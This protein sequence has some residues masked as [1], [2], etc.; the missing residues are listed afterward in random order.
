MGIESAL[1]PVEKNERQ[2][3]R[4]TILVVR[5][6]RLLRILRR[7]A[8]HKVLVC[9]AMA[10]VPMAIRLAALRAIPIPQAWVHDEF[11]YILA[12]ETF[13]SGRLTNPTH[14]MWQHFET[15]HELMRPTYQSKYPPAQGMFLAL[16][17]KLFGHPWYGVWLGFGMMCGCICWMLQGW[18]PPLYALLGTLVAIGQIGI[19]GYWMDSYWGGAVAAAGGALALGALPRMARSASVTA[20]ALGSVGVL[21]LANSRPYE[22]LVMLTG[23]AAG[24]LWWRHRRGRPLRELFSWRNAAPLLLIGAG[25]AAWMGYYNYRVTGTPWKLPYMVYEDTYAA[26]PQWIVLPPMRHP[27]Q[28]R[29]AVLEQFWTEEE[30]PQY[31][32]A[33]RNPIRA[34]LKSMHDALPFYFSTLL[35]AA[36]GA[37]LLLSKSRKLWLAAG[38]AAALWFGSLLE[39]WYLPHYLAGGAGLVFVVAMYGIRL[40]RVRTGRVGAAVMLLVVAVPF[41]NGLAN[42][43]GTYQENHVLPRTAVTR[44]LLAQGGRHLVIVRYGPRH[45]IYGPEWVFNAADINA[46]PIVWARDMGVEKNRELLRYYADRK[47]WLLTPEPEVKL[48]PYEP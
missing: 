44:E 13:R 27:P 16:G 48:M 37:A 31:V 8:Q 39:L 23:A 34:V 7:A 40:L 20:S 19:F 35:F 46:S 32:A 25:G 9:F 4:R 17:W 47:V 36:A 33:R 15:F 41:L 10:L 11:S 38:I 26:V 18:M 45:N 43:I 24:L 14:P 30:V 6:D 1:S 29:H 3:N 2:A 42:A 28:F 12:A 5:A 22:G 21:L